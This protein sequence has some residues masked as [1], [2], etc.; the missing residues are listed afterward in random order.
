MTKNSMTKTNFGHLV[1]GICKA[2][3]SSVIWI[4]KIM[5]KQKSIIKFKIN[6]KEY[7]TKV[8][9]SILKACGENGVYIPTLC[10]APIFPLSASCRI[11]LVEVKGCQGL[12][13]A[14]ST[15]VAEGMEIFTETEK[16]KKAR[17]T[18]LKLLY[19]NHIGKCPKCPRFLSCELKKLVT[20]YK[21]SGDL[22]GERLNIP[23]DDSGAVVFDLNKCIKCRRCIWACKVYGSD[24]LTVKGKGFNCKISTKNGKKLKDSGCISCKQCAKVCPVGAIFEK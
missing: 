14:C 13:T 12:L 9:I 6:N 11:C 2:E 21:A 1:I 10:Y 18:N 22:K 24:V 5:D 20:K 15:Q 3:L 19:Q 17:K 8:G 4:F 23:V 16:I 7:R